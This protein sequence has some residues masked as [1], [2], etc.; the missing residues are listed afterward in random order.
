VSRPG[1]VPLRAEDALFLHAQTRFLCQQVGAVLLLEPGALDIAE[2]RAA[3]R[4]RVLRVPELRRRLGAAR[5]R[6]RRPCW[7]ADTDADYTERVRDVLIGDAGVPRTLGGVID[8][9]FSQWCDPYRRPWEIL[10]I[11]ATPRE[12]TAVAVKI[13]HAL[14]DSHT[15]IG[16]L[17][18]LFDST[19]GGT[20]AA[21]SARARSRGASRGAWRG[22]ARAA[23]HALRGLGYLAAAGS[24]PDVSVCGPFTSDRRR[25]MA[26]GFSARD[27]AMT[28]RGLDAGIGDL[29][30]AVIAEALSGLLRSRGEETAGRVVRVAMPRAHPR[31]AAGAARQNRTAA[32]SLD[33]PIGP[34]TPEQRLAAVRG[35]IA[36]HVNRGEDAAAALVLRAMNI[37]PP[38]L[39]RFIAARVYQRRWF[40]M[41]VSVFPGIRRSYR[42]LG[43][44]VEQAYP[45][46][47]LAD[48]VGLS[49]GAMTWDRSFSV[50][51]LADAAL[52][53]DVD[54]LA[55]EFT[56]AFELY[57]AAAQPPAPPARGG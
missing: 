47:A 46:L 7:V 38:P 21:P 15:I 48:G 42:L 16:A 41:L 37:L 36:A 17:A 32:I 26:V 34:A 35:Q 55:A 2:F 12:V 6:W 52:V 53:P 44:R 29:L 10:L 45:V 13:H 23:A 4:Q 51:I 22:R 18:Q 33:V 31:R 57:Q 9:F 3:V 54:K 19:G 24:A 5:G 30:L 28:A 20:A 40:N 43:A 1:K 27:V 56:G 39:Q 14:G 25:F 49:I 8:M 11:R 50:G